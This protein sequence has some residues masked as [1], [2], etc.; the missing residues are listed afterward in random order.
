[1]PTL[2]QRILSA[3]KW[4][5]LSEIATKVIP[6]LVYVILARILVPEDFGVVAASAMVISFSTIIWDAGL[7]KALIQREH[8]LEESKNVVFLTNIV[9]S[10]V[11][12]AMLF[13]AAPFIA[14]LFSDPRV[15][16]VLRVQ[17]VQ[18]ILM[19]LGSV[20]AAMYA[21]DLNF[22]N[23]FWVRLVQA[24]FPGLI[25][26]PLAIAGYGYWALVYGY[27][28]GS[29]LRS[30]MLWWLDPWRP[31]WTYN[32]AL[33]GQLFRFALWSSA[34]GLLIWLYLWMDSFMVVSYLGSHD[35]GLYRTGTYLVMMVFNLL[36]SPIAPIL[37]SAFSRL[38]SD[39]EKMRK[40]LL[41]TIKIITM[42]CLPS[43]VGL[44]LVRK[45]LAAVIFNQSW[46]GIDGIVGIFGLTF[47]FSYIVFPAGEAFRGMGRPDLLVK[48]L[49][50]A[51]IFIYL[52]T[53]LFTVKYGLTVFMYGRLFSEVIG[54]LF[55][56][57]L[58]LRIFRIKLFKFINTIGW[59][60][61][62]TA[63]MSIGVLTLL[64]FKLLPSGSFYNLALSVM[65]GVMLYI[66]F[67]FKEI[68]IIINLI[69]Y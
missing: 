61:L 40:A 34:E 3:S 13:F 60:V 17:G 10:L 52:P 5:T 15:A 31:R 18:I 62:S 47:C 37:F 32:K 20:Q 42:L 9:L 45:S 38:Q 49:L 50:F 44:F 26:L 28:F 7:S 21:R 54:S 65:I 63:G 36:L 59:S 33:A 35:L 22:K 53:Y 57:G 30:I 41:K 23:L 56:G 12:Y 24:T 66:T 58:M 4:S 19:A 48:Y 51:L 2:K 64:H 43:G 29:L 55:L 68:K 1:M 25:S 8:D 69:R 39:K 14:G 67:N 16:P 11:I 6:P 27:L 46:I